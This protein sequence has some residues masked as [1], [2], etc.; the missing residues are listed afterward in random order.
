MKINQ[1]NYEL[2]F[3]DYF[4]GKLSPVET[5]E[6]MYF[7]SENPDLEKEFNAFGP[8]NVPGTHVSFRDKDALKKDFKDVDEI[9]TSNFEEFCIGA[10]ENDLDAGSHKKL[11]QYLQQ[12][13]EKKDRFTAFEKTRL[14]PDLSVIYTGKN[15]LKR[16][17][18]PVFFRNRILYIAGAAAAIL[19][20]VIVF[21][22][23]DYSTGEVS[24]GS[25]ANNAIVTGKQDESLK[26]DSNAEE[27]NNSG[28]VRLAALPRKP[29]KISSMEPADTCKIY[30]VQKKEPALYRMKPIEVTTI[31]RGK[32]RE[33]LLMA[34]HQ[35]DNTVDGT[36]KKQGM[37]GLTGIRDNLSELH[38]SSSS[39]DLNFWTLANAGLK[40][41][42]Y[43]TESNLEI[44]RKTNPEGDIT[45]YGIKSESFSI[46]TNRKK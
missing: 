43:L 33:D 8:L 46:S 27:D 23:R 24:T 36:E 5:A 20:A 1:H 31:S 2:C 4:D 14:H 17:P 11:M 18:A 21:R 3:I 22:N 41:V 38:I 30:P 13:P 9:S 40:G 12:H 45:T 29:E 7:L 34:S 39:G 10:M 19:L 25:V 28:T 44:I 35:I 26:T 16:I 15:A 37:P 6:L 42:N 32:I